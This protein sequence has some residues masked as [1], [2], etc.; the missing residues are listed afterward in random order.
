MATRIIL[1]PTDFSKHSRVALDRA[2]ELAKVAPSK[3]VLL[4]SYSV[5]TLTVGVTPFSLPEH[6][7]EEL[8]KGASAELDRVAKDVVAAGVPCEVRLSGLPEV[9]AILEAAEDLPADLIA[10]GT[11][12]H[13]GFKHALLGSIAERI[14]RLAPCPVLTAK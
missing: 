3:I 7:I 5:H 6:F 9:D 14:V 11:R 4:H 10:M 13:T 1:V 2:I 8:R 12:G